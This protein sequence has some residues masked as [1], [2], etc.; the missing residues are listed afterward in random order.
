MF[1]DL[2]GPLVLAGMNDD[3]MPDFSLPRFYVANLVDGMRKRLQVR[4]RALVRCPSS[5]VEALC[6]VH[7]RVCSP[8]P[9]DLQ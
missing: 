5:R 6:A 1:P 9:R 3:V 4:A 8:P 7:R 2:V